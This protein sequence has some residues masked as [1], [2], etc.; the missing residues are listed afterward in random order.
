MWRHRQRHRHLPQRLQTFTLM[1]SDELPLRGVS[2]GRLFQQSPI[3]LFQKGK[4]TNIQVITE[5]YFK[6]GRS[7]GGMLADTCLLIARMKEAA[8]NSSD[9]LS[10]MDKEVGD[11]TGKGMHAPYLYH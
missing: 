1:Y 8:S 11:I 7:K 4:K 10:G 9:L 6:I 2:N 5:I 3:I